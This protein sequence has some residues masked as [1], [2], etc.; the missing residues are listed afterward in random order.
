MAQQDESL[1]RAA[2]RVA[3]ALS[4]RGHNGE[5]RILSDSA[6]SA[7]EAAAALG[8]AQEQIVKSMVFRGRSSGQAILALVGGLSRV[9]TALLAAFAGEAV[10]RADA[11]WVREQTGFAIGGVPPVGHGDGVR[12]VAE[13]SLVPFPLLWAAAGTPH[14][15][16]PLRGDELVELTGAE[17]ASIASADGR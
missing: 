9:D 11:D 17:L 8:V 13:R 6:R 14:A 1:P 12:T 2:R 5:I 4:A 16:F 15:V 3:E 7:A 10:E